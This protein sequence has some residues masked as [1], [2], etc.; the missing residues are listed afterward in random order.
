MCL[1]L[2]TCLSVG[3][4]YGRELRKYE[5]I[6][7]RVSCEIEMSKFSNS[8]KTLPHSSCDEGYKSY[9]ISDKLPGIQPSH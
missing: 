2:F 7:A 1:V 3:P 4:A 9:S 8:E 5:N 6:Q